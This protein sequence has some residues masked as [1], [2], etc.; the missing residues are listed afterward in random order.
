[1]SEQTADGA[2]ESFEAFSRLTLDLE[3]A[4]GLPAGFLVSL[5]KEDDWSFV[6]KIHSLVEAA[7]TQRITAAVGDARLSPVFE[8]LQLGQE[9]T[10]KLGFAKALDLLQPDELRYIRALAELRN[11]LVHYIDQVRF[12]FTEYFASL[13]KNRTDEVLRAFTAYPL[14]GAMPEVKEGLRARFLKHP[15][16]LI[17]VNA[18][19]IVLVTRTLKEKAAAE[20]KLKAIGRALRAVDEAESSEAS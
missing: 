9:K 20:R 6:V 8:R 7:V 16:P 18:I 14:D 2:E 10:G 4:L 11:R 19:R 17:W 15:K 12:S 3:Q 13:D 1:M 5:W